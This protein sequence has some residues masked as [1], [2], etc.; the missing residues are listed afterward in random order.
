M[1]AY[2]PD[3]LKGLLGTVL[4][5]IACILGIIIILYVLIYI[6]NENFKF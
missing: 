2:F 5:V 1:G 4:T 6:V 3:W